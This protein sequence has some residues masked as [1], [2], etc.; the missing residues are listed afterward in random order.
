MAPAMTPVAMPVALGAVFA[1]AVLIAA[2]AFAALGPWTP[3]GASTPMGSRSPTPSPAL[4][5]DEPVDGGRDIV[6]AADGTGHFW[7]LTEAVAAAVDGDR[8]VLEPGTYHES[9][10]IDKHISIRG[11]GDRAAVIIEP[12][13][14]DSAKGP[15]ARYYPYSEDLVEG[16]EFVVYLDQSDAQLSDLTI[17][18]GEIGTAVVVNG[19]APTIT[20]VVIDPDGEQ[21]NKTGSA[22]HEGLA[23]GGSSTATIQDSLITAFI[24]IGEASRATLIGNTIQ[25]SCLVIDGVDAD[26]II[27]E[28]RV[29]GSQ[30]PRMSVVVSGGA[31]PVLEANVILSDAQTDGIRVS[32]DGS[33]PQISGNTVTGG[34]YGIWAGN[35]AAPNIRR[36]LVTGARAGVGVM[37]ADAV[38][39]TNEIRS[40]DTGVVLDQSAVPVFV[41][42]TVCDNRVNVELRGGATLPS[43]DNVICAD[44]AERPVTMTGS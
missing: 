40:N 3:L 31:S 37:G 29:E 21:R 25:G 15:T 42:N 28:N 26:P 10:T 30:C 32:G 20:N 14:G 39:D 44:G 8:I 34:D 18:G 22:P 12:A 11:D 16:W 6:V 23:I 7:S 1:A 27:R 17:R 9:L 5:L 13:Q 36:N 4:R 35:G 41:G 24:G 38:L 2:V 33:A 19:G 43:V